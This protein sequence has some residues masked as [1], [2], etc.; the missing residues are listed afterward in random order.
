MEM[1]GSNLSKAG[2]VKEK[3]R[4]IKGGEGH[5]GETDGP[6]VKVLWELEEKKGFQ[7]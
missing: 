5:I 2:G 1:V 6:A 3:V 4:V 7:V